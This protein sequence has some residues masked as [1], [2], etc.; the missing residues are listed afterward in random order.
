MIDTVE[1]TRRFEPRFDSQGLIPCVVTDAATGEVVMFAWMNDEALQA[2]LRTRRA[3]YWSRSRGALW[4]KGATSGAGQHV[5]EMRTDC[6]QDVLLLKVER[7]MPERTCH[8][9][10]NTCFYRIVEEDDGVQTLRLAE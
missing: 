4:E 1:E 10:R 6:D 3:H 2:T 8:T 7:T 5:L 9:G